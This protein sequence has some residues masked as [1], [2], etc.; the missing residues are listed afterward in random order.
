MGKEKSLLMPLRIVNVM[1][2]GHFEQSVTHSGSEHQLMEVVLSADGLDLNFSFKTTSEM[3]G[4]GM[5][6]LLKVTGF[7]SYQ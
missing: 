5:T 1:P 3:N 7:R 6:V 4:T 2:L